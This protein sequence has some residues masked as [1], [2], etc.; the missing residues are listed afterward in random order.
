MLV[1]EGKEQTTLKGVLATKDETNQ[2]INKSPDVERALYRQCPRLVPPEFRPQCVETFIQIR[3]NPIAE[4]EII[5]TRSKK[6]TSK[7]P[8]AKK[9]PVRK[10]KTTA[11]PPKTTMKMRNMREFFKPVD[12]DEVELEVFEAPNTSNTSNLENELSILNDSLRNNSADLAEV[13]VIEDNA[14]PAVRENSTIP[15]IPF[16]VKVAKLIERYHSVKNSSRNVPSSSEARLRI[17]ITQ[18]SVPNQLKLDVLKKN[19]EFV[20]KFTEGPLTNSDPDVRKCIEQIFSGKRKVRQFLKEKPEKWS[21]M[22]PSNQEAIFQILTQLR[23]PISNNSF[24]VDQPAPE[25]QFIANTQVDYFIDTES[26]LP[27]FFENE[28]RYESQRHPSQVNNKHFAGTLSSTPIK[29]ATSKVAKNKSLI[30]SPIAKA[31]ERCNRK[32]NIMNENLRPTVSTVHS[33]KTDSLSEA[34]DRPALKNQNY[35]Q[36]LGLTCLDDLFA[37]DDET[38]DE[39]VSAKDVEEDSFVKPAPLQT[40]TT[41]RIDNHSHIGEPSKI[42]PINKEISDIFVDSVDEIPGTQNVIDP[43]VSSIRSQR[44]MKKNISNQNDV[45]MVSSASSDKENIS[46]NR[47]LFSGDPP[48]K[49]LFIGTVNDMFAYDSDSDDEVQPKEDTITKSDETIPKSDS[50]C[51]QEYDFDE[52]IYNSSQLGEGKA[53]HS[54]TNGTKGDGEFAKLIL[55]LEAGSSVMR[56]GGPIGRN[57]S[58]DIFAMSDSSKSNKSASYVGLEH[59]E[60]DHAIVVT[61]RSS[62]PPTFSKNMPNTT[63]SLSLIATSST[64]FIGKAEANPCVRTSSPKDNSHRFNNSRLPSVPS[65]LNVYSSGLGVSVNSKH[66]HI[67]KTSTN[68]SNVRLTPSVFDSPPRNSSTHADSLQEMPSPSLIRRGP[69]LSRLR[70]KVGKEPSLNSEKNVF[71]SPQ[72]LTCKPTTNSG[73][74]S[75]Y[76]SPDDFEQPQNIQ[77]KLGRTSKL[78]SD[79]HKDF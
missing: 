20:E 38:S 30:D 14:E 77:S 29:K 5:T 78:Q 34:S 54:V 65:V 62:S 27:V 49:K 43:E 21:D 56:N 66:D 37:D 39:A 61:Q 18:D 75:N 28:S 67:S 74:T 33:T 57:D 40:M 58:E 1:T 15:R 42:L 2:R 13:S 47:S 41:D 26:N 35:L 3:D 59:K 9:P 19:R 72:F 71:G 69:N 23:A 45:G 36:Y 55:S 52:I 7:E 31:F 44:S 46:D 63:K 60:S 32:N 50:D 10:G 68:T 8:A 25:P 73:S 17:I 24:V 16:A 79:Q 12:F 4:P 64:S 70:Y 6:K 76:R 11:K 48:R 51:T 53:N 22:S